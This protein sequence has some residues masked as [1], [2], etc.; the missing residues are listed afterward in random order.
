MILTKFKKKNSIG[1]SVFG[2]KNEVKYPIYVLKKSF[3]EKHVNYSYKK[4]IKGTIFLSKLLI[5]LC[6][7]IHYIVEKNIFV[8]IAYE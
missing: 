8:V 5:H 2:Y 6:M 3:E 4:K 7:I 1:I